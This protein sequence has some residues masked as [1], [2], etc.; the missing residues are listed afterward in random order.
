MQKRSFTYII[1]DNGQ[2]DIINRKPI[3]NFC[4]L[5]EVDVVGNIHNTWLFKYLITNGFI[6]FQLRTAPSFML[7]N[8]GYTNEQYG[9]SGNNYAGFAIWLQDGYTNNL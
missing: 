3:I 6:Q 8:E 5:S 1:L 2:V 7:V 9:N 4:D